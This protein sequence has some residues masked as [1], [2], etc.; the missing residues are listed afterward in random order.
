MKEGRK[1]EDFPLQV[2]TVLWSAKFRVEFSAY[3]QE[4]DVWK[5]ASAFFP[6]FTTSFTSLLNIMHILVNLKSRPVGW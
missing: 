4:Q 5:F 1:T 6:L 2:R 3:S